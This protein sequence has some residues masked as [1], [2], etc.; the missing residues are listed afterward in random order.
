MNYKKCYKCK[1]EK[2]KSE[3]YEKS[4]SCKPCG[5]EM[6]RDYKRRNKDKISAYNKKYKKENKEIISKYNREYSLKNRKTIQKRHS[7]YLKNRKKT[8][9]VYKMSLTLRNRIR[10]LFK[11]I[12]KKDDSTKNLLGCS[13]D[14]FVKWFEFQFT[15]DMTMQNHGKVWHIDH[16]VP[17]ASFNILDPDEQR[18]CFHWTNMQPLHCL[19]NLS[20]K[21]N[22]DDFMI[23]RQIKKMHKFIKTVNQDE[24]NYKKF[25]KYQITIP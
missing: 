7:A 20:K 17:C 2:P 8:N 5:R 15:D 11:G 14:F 19:E 24:F 10:G 22:I 6:C 1:L 23:K 13:Y 12:G 16:V 3:F 18:K 21:D 4:F 25:T 9:P